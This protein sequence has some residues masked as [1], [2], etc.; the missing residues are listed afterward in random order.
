MKLGA[1]ISPTYRS[2]AGY[3]GSTINLLGE[4]VLPIAHN[5]ISALYTFLVVAG[6]KVNLL[7]RDLFEKFNIRVVC[8]ANAVSK[9]G[10]SILEEFST[11]LSENFQSAVK[12]PVHLDINPEVVPIYGK[13]RQ[14]PVRL[15]DFQIR[16][17]PIS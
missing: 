14:I 7:G 3:G 4:T 15:K 10:T 16:I 6:S 12:E 11:Y 1:T 8:D 2:V 17:G 13:A 5:T 9:V